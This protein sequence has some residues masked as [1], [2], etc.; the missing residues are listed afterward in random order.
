MSWSSSGF[1]AFDDAAFDALAKLAFASLLRPEEEEE[2]GALRASPALRGVS[3]TALKEG[4][5][6]VCTLLLT[7]AQDGADAGAFATAL[8]EH[9]IA[10]PRA[11]ALCAQYKADA[12]ALRGVLTRTG[13]GL[14]SLVGADWRLDYHVSSSA[15]G[16]ANVPVYCLKWKTVADPGGG[17]GGGAGSGA[18]HKD[19]EFMCSLQ[20]LQ[21]L[22]NSINDAAKQIER[23]LDAM[24]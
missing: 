5:A 8:E 2:E 11:E 15:T 21:D 4:F 13:I 9:G 18:Q 1:A 6:G 10:G 7:A 14:P 17:A 22:S 16:K 3:P 20:Q 24:S 23:T 19:I 12:A